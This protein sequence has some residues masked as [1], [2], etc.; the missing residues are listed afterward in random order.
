M[1]VEYWYR[2]FDGGW[3][4]AGDIEVVYYEVMKH[5]P[6]GVWLHVGDG[7]Q[8]FVL[9]PS[10]T[11]RRFAYPTLEQALM[12]YRY[13]KLRQVQH[14]KM[15]LERAEAQLLSVQNIQALTPVS[16]W[17]G[18]GRLDYFSAKTLRRS[19]DYPDFLTLE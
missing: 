16:R 10:G 4:R 7:E 14:K 17:H 8:R 2:L 6:C 1:S 12:S 5:T 9:Q 19:G 3:D 15:E 11:S 13:R 18:Y